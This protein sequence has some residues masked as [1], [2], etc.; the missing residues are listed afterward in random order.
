MCS[1]TRSECSGLVRTMC[2]KKHGGHE[3]ALSTMRVAYLAGSMDCLL[4]YLF[5]SPV[6]LMVSV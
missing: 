1:A 4:S 2:K 3:D 6:A 5:D